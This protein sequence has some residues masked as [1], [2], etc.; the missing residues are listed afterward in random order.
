[1]L[2]ETWRLLQALE[3]S[4]IGRAS[5]HKRM[6][7]PGRSS[8]CVRVCLDKDGKV[9]SVQDIS[10]DDWPSWTVMEGNQS[11]FPVVRVQEPLIDM[12]R[13]HEAWTKLG[14]H[15]QVKR[16]R[17]PAEDVRIDCLEDLLKSVKIRELS[18]KAQSLWQRL[19][20]QKAKE[21]GNCAKND[22]SKMKQVGLLAERF[23]QAA[24]EPKV[25]LKQVAELSVASLRQGRLTAIDAVEQLMVGKGP[26][27]KEGKP[28]AVT[29]QLA[30]DIEETEDH[31]PRLYSQSVKDRLVE[32]L[33]QDPFWKRS[34]AGRNQ[35]ERIGV[36]ALTGESAELETKNFP[37]VDLPVP[38]AARRG[39]RISRKRFPLASM[40]S[41][42]RCNTRY[43]MTDARVFPVA[44]TRA[45]HLKE[46]LEEITADGR[47]EKTWQHVAS[48]RFDTQSGR[49]IEK[50][51]LLI[52]YVEEKPMLDVKTAGYFGQGRSVSEAKF[53]VDAAAVCKAFRGI[54]HG[55]PNSKLNLFLIR[56]ASKG[57]TQIVLA[58]SPTVKDVLEA[59]E[60][61]QGAVSDNIPHVTMYLPRITR[62][63]LTLSAVEDAQPL[64]PYPDQVVRLLSHQWVRNGSSPRD[65]SGKLQKANQEIVG[66]GLAEVLALMLRMEGKWEPAARHML[67][68]LIRRVGPLLIG[69]F[70]A[71][72]AYG[73]RH[74]QGR[75]EPFFD[76]PRSS[77]ETSLRAVAV[78][79]ILL[80]ALGSGKEKYMKDAP[81]QV[82]Q[83]MSL[84]DTLHK[85]YCTVVRRGQLPNSLIGTSL[86]RRALDNPAGAL[87]DLSERILEYVRWAKVARA[88]HEWS[89][90]DQRRIAVNEARKKLRQFQPLA[91]ELSTCD[92]PT[93]CTDVMKAQILL[94]F[95]AVPPAEEQNDE[96]KEEN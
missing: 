78:F 10:D 4:D 17:K 61:W 36:D 75:H 80:D 13:N 12:K 14:Y 41:E 66:P 40:F 24:M 84:A 47:R 11:S 74:S 3:R 26:P 91:A 77:R 93:E 29:V 67:E 19:R 88:S 42:A 71:K 69:V 94:G 30:F 6:Q 5:K 31:G 58:Q 7:T 35:S 87:A 70:G 33:P 15:A 76:Y 83:V 53:E 38:T 43:G 52:A 81:Y 56:E 21:L 89:P 50:P 39:K 92:L 8:P 23:T 96:G 85:D 37:K 18:D 51:D 95:M 2:N 22:E 27:D 16:R 64:A 63:D 72:Y 25:L 32:V 68:L 54:V 57:Q 73:P 44:Q 79:G 48:G 55:K 82:G 62:N 20:D 65:A 9:G 49:K 28:P 1:M 45:T 86:M 90:D 46:A 60:R 59:A 34:F